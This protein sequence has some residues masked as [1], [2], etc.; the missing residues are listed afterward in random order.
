MLV[1]VLGGCFHLLM[2]KF[3]LRLRQESNGIHGTVD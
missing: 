2:Y 3:T 1:G